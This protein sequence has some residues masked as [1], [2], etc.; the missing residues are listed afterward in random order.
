MVLNQE[1]L[2]LFA[3][4][5]PAHARRLVRKLRV[6]SFRIDNNVD[7]SAPRYPLTRPLHQ[8]LPRL[9]RSRCCAKEIN[10]SAVGFPLIDPVA[11]HLQKDPRPMRCWIDAM[12]VWYFWGPFN[13]FP[14]FRGRWM[15][16]PT[17][18]YW[19]L[20]WISNKKRS[21]TLLWRS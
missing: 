3:D 17:D 5:L 1:Y 19:S 11:N 4:G 15:A 12:V 10:M 14:C 20:S 9:Q 21:L 2:W 16:C 8:A 18:A 13:V 6:Q 7:P